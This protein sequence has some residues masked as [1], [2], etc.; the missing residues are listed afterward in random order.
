MA[1]GGYPCVGSVRQ[2][3]IRNKQERPGWGGVEFF[4]DGC[5]NNSVYQSH[6]T[7]T[8]GRLFLD[9]VGI[10]LSMAYIADRTNADISTVIGTT[11]ISQ[12]HQTIK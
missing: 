6:P 5:F 12:E 8:N 10:T 9:N 4:R 11:H 1:V 3:K 7:Q 2:G